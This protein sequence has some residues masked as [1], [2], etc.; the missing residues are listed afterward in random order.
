MRILIFITTFLCLGHPCLAESNVV[1]EHDPVTGKIIMRRRAAESGDAKVSANSAAS[2][3]VAPQPAPS[4]HKSTANDGQAV[5]NHGPA[6]VKKS[7]VALAWLGLCIAG[8][9]YIGLLATMAKVNPLWILGGILFPPSSLIF[10]FTNW[11]AAKVSFFL[12]LIGVVICI[13]A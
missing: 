7:H 10:V 1:I 3:Q 11:Q 12:L 2:T 6:P 8:L 5:R 4:F 9:G 13:I